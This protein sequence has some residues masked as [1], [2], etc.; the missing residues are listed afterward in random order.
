[1]PK[2]QR[3]EETNILFFGSYYSVDFDYRKYLRLMKNCQKCQNSN[4]TYITSF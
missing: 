3:K 1:M 4:T 2:F